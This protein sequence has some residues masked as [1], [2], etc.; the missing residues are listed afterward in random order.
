MAGVAVVVQGLARGM[1]GAPLSAWQLRALLG[2]PELGTLSMNGLDDLIGVM[3]DLKKILDRFDEGIVDIYVRDCVGDVGL[4]D[5]GPLAMSP[6]IIVRN[7]PVPN[8]QAAFGEGSGTE[9]DALLSQE[10]CSGRTST[11]TC[12]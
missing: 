3:P 7:A 4:P 10:C 8:P 9:D 6:D 5:P 11:C 1:F 2:D 12:G